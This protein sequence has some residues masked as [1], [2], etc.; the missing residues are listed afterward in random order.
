MSQAAGRPDNFHHLLEWQVLM[1]LS[2]QYP[3]PDLCQQCIT[4]QRRGCIDAHGQG[5]DE[6]PDQLF[7]LRTT[8]SCNRAADHHFGL[9][10]KTRQQCAPCGQ[11]GHVQRDALPLRQRSQACRQWTVQPHVQA[12]T[13]EVLLRRA[14]PVGR[15]R[16]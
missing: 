12:G 1:T 7:Q 13:G 6:Q 14:G 5:V 3:L 11:Q 9:T 15:Q 4:G 8:A 16:Q 10:G 2:L